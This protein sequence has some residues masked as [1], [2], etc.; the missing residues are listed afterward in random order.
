MKG[1]KNNRRSLKKNKRNTTT[2]NKQF[3]FYANNCDR[4]SGKMEAFDK[5]LCDLKPSV[6]ALEETKRKINDPPMKCTNVENY[7][8]FE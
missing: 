2:N 6:F 8:V 4:L 1:K 3:I 7:Q 5:V